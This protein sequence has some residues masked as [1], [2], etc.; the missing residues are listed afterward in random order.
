LKHFIMFGR[1]P[2]RCIPLCRH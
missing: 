1:I 2:S